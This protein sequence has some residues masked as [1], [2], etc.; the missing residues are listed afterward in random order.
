MF[1]L[2][3]VVQFQLCSKVGDHNSVKVLE[4]QQ[5]KI[6]VCKDKLVAQNVPYV[7]HFLQISANSKEALGVYIL[8]V[9]C[10]VHGVV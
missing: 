3:A 9:Q 1:T 4:G 7:M 10:F 8:S 6:C 5:L 2:S